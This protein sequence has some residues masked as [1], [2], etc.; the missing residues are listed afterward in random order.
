MVECRLETSTGYRFLASCAALLAGSALFIAP[1]PAC[2]AAG[3]GSFTMEQ[4]LAYPFVPELD[5]AEKGDAIAFVRVVKGVRNV[6]VADGPAFK[7]RQV[8]QYTADDGQEITQ[9]TFS[10]D[11]KHLVYVRGGDHDANWEA[12]LPPDPDSSSTEPKVTIWAAQLA[13]GAPVK[14][15]EGDAPA[16]SSL[17]ELAYVKDKQV[18]TTPLNGKG[19][20]RRLLFD[21]GD[22]GDLAWSPDGTKLAFVSNRD[23]DHS[24]VTVYDMKT[25]ALTYLAPSTDLDGYPAW[26]PDGTRIAFARRP[27]KGGAPKPLLRQ[28]PNPFSLWVADVASG[29]ATRVW[30]SPETLHGSF[31]QTA[32]EVNLHWADGDRLVFLADLDNWPHLYSIPAAGGAPLLLTPGNY[33]VEHVAMSRDRKSAIFDANTGTTPDDGDRRHVFRVPVDAGTPVALTSGTSL[34]W[35]PVAASG[36]EVAFIDAGPQA[37]PSLSVVAMDGSARHDLGA[38]TVPSEFPQAQLI[39]PRSVTFRAADGWTI[40]GQLFDSGSSG[41]SGGRKPALIFVHGGPPRQM[42]LGWHYMDYYSNGYAVNQYL[43][44]HGYVVLSVN[45][46]LGIGYGHDFHHPDHGGAAGAAEYQDVVA[47]ARYLQSLAD[48]DPA[49]IGIWGG[50]YGGF[51]TA[52]ALARNS[53]IFKA[54]VDLHGVHDWSALV[55]ERVDKQPKRYEQGDAEQAIKVAFDSSPIAS[56]NGWRSPVLL[57]QGDDDRNVHFQQTIDLARRLEER[58]VP[59]EQ[60]V[61]PNEIHGFLRWQSWLAADTATAGFFARTLPAK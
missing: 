48:V 31:P 24:F 59:F 3:P 19:K 49:E 41:G 58:H 16:I 44:N 13:G 17:G 60:F 61:I 10:P 55:A 33:M 47:G 53:D 4:V 29:R 42:L 52:M 50:S 39:A 36:S 18:W 56:V 40:H 6:W 2:A 1:A 15:A 7:P 32:G 22:D 43:A 23:G 30:Q 26:S 45:Y 20:P 51:L 57:I 8:T 5:A 37:P 38:G 12:K 9:L 46:R 11:G 54:G 34:E 27:G 25:K 35:S 28:T 14:I 21:R